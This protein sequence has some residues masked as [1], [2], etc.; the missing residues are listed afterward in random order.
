[1]SIFGLEITWI[2]FFGVIFNLLGVWL[3]IKKS[4]YCFP[5]G[6]IGVSLYVI[7][8]FQLRLYADMFLQVFYIGLLAYGWKQWTKT[9][10]EENFIVTGLKTQQW[11]LLLFICIGSTL[12]IGT[13]FNVFTDAALPYLD[14]LLTS[15]SLVAQWL[16]A[17]KKLENWLV[18]IAADI[19]YVGLFIFKASYPTA[20]LYF[21][22]IILA[23]AGYFNWKK[24]IFVAN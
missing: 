19:I 16:I 13:V 10:D 3:T 20:I 9:G 14:A 4:R 21:I 8:F 2:E 22:F 1:M 18:W 24:K 7:Y 6:I 23:V 11:L 12:L 5:A 17:K 15:M